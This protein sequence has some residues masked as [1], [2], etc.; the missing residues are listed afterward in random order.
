MSAKLTI[1]PIGEAE[2]G[3]CDCCGERSRRVWGFVHSNTAAYAAYFVHWTEGHLVDRGATFDIVLGR[4]GNGTSAADRVATRLRSRHGERLDLMVVDADPDAMANLAGT[5]L[6]RD[7]VIG[8][9]IADEI[10]SICDA[11]IA[12]DERIGWAEP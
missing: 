8:E 3:V 5:A 7:D 12:Q 2:T 10:F 1:E 4:W 11:V 6:R 9:P